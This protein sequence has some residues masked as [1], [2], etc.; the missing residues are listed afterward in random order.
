MTKKPSP[1]VPSIRFPE[2]KGEWIERK[3]NKYFASSRKKGTE[4]L[5][6][7]SVTQNDGLVRRDSLDRQ[8]GV[9]AGFEQN[10]RAEKDDLVYNMMRM[11]QGAVGKAIEPCMVSPAYVVLS[12]RKIAKS[13]FF[14]Y[15]FNRK[16]A[17][18]WLWAYSYGLTNDRLRLYY[19]DFAQIPF[20]APEIDEQEKIASFLGA[21][22]AK[23]AQLGK[24]QELLMEYKKGVMQQIFTQK[25]RFK[26]DNGNDFPTWE[27]KPF[28]KVY[29]FQRTNS[30]SRSDLDDK[31]GTIQNIHY[32]D[33]HSKLRPQFRYAR[34]SLPFVRS[35]VEMSQIQS[36]SFCQ[37]GDVVL[38][39]ASEDYN[40]VGKAIEIVEVPKAKVLA[41]LH[42]ILARPIN[43]DLVVGFSGYLLRCSEVRRQVMRFAQGISVLGISKGSL[44]QV[45]LPIPCRDEQ[46]KIATFLNSLDDAV[47]SISVEISRMQVFKQGLLQQMFA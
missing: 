10:L 14:L 30:L 15:M 41:G 21:V 2:F 37:P 42:T 46:L 19:K 44:S 11:W 3:A 45:L 25:I 35:D 40:D 16:R 36:E 8:I 5:P 13:Q 38:A 34:E 32:G 24:K 12:P 31:A 29:S 18:Y 1:S 33:I 7:Y 9:D 39:D 28:G 22:D 17:L 47:H 6:I 23:I 27:E 43:N 4:G 26:D 20:F